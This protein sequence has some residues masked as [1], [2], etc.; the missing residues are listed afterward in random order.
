[1][2]E[3]WLPVIGFPGYEVSDQGRVRSLDR[4]IHYAASRKSI[5]Y[6]MLRQG[7]ILR[8]GPQASGHLTVLL[9]R[10][11]G[12]RLVHHLV[13]EAFLGPCPPGM[14]GRHL[15]GDPVHNAFSNLVW[16]TR[17]N[18]S[19]DKKWHDGC[20]HYKLKP[21]QI[22]AIKTRLQDSYH[23]LLTDLAREFNVSVSAISHIKQGRVHID[24]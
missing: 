3:T 7:R 14:E 16:D 23:G 11:G 17:G 8:P 6:A 12:S 9:G 2:I 1:M 19:R 5:A 21:P 22:A 20:V 15:D 4:M 13:L 24:V 10:A 18:N